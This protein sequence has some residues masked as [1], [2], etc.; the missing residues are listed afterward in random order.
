MQAQCESIGFRSPPKGDDPK[1]TGRSGFVCGTGKGRSPRKMFSN[2][3][4]T[5]MTNSPSVPIPETKET[6]A[7][8]LHSI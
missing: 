3:Y 1:L 6:D 7:P 8:G 5:W 4:S 2:A